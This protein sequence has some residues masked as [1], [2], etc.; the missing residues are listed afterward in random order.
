M[1]GNQDA[2]RVRHT[3]SPGQIRWPAP[4]LAVDE[5]AESAEHE[6]DA[7]QRG[8][9]VQHIPDVLAFCAREH[10]GRDQHTGHAPM[11]GHAA[12]PQ[13]KD[14]QPTLGDHIV[15]VEN[16]PAYAA[17]HDDADGAVENEIVDVE[18]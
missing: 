18:R 13:M 9:K 16:A 1:P 15:S 3:E 8:D 11:K 10:D 17:A 4:K 7:R 2:L 12:V 14:I 5:I 6:P